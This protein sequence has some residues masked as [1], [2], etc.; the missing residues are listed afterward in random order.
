MR[1]HLALGDPRSPPDWGLL[2]RMD[3]F[4]GKAAVAR[5]QKSH[6]ESQI[7]GQKP[8][9]LSMTVFPGACK[10]GLWA[11]AGLRLENASNQRG[12]ALFASQGP[13]MNECNCVDGPMQ[14][15]VKRQKAIMGPKRYTRA[16]T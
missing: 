7:A 9:R 10:G 5:W 15:E 14:R 12:A 6:P 3:P 1:A 16:L 8:D 13:P 2:S 11:E 4:N